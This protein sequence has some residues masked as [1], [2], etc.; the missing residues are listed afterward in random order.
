[1]KTNL[2]KIGQ[3]VG[4]WLALT[5]FGL[6]AYGASAQVSNP[7]KDFYGPG[8]YPAWT[9]EINWANSVNMATF[10]TGANDFE[11]FEAAR[12]LLFSQ[13]GGV[14]YYPAGTYNF[15]DHPQGPTGRGL[16]LRKGVVIVGEPP[17]ADK[18]AIVD[19]ANPGLTQ[20]GTKFLFPYHTTPRVVNGSG[21]YPDAWNLIGLKAEAGGTLKDV[22]HVG[23]AWVN[24]DAAYVYMGP[25]MPWS[26]SPWAQA[27]A[28][29]SRF[30]KNTGENWASR[31]ADGTHPMDPFMGAAP[32]LPYFGGSKGRFVFGC[33][34]DNSNVPNYMCSEGIG[35]DYDPDYV[36][37]F[38]FAARIAVYGANVL[39]ANNAVPIAP[40]N[41]MMAQPIKA[42]N[43]PVSTQNIYY[44][45][46]YQIGLDVNKQLVSQRDNRCNLDNG[47][48]YEKGVIIKDNWIFNHGNKG[49]EFCGKWVTIKNNVN[50]RYPINS[51]TARYGLPANWVL[52]R[53]GYNVSN[54]IDDNMA[55]AMDFGGWN[56]WM[57]HNWYTGTG[58]DPG[59]D[60]EGM[61]IQRHGGVEV[62]SF[63]WTYNRQGPTGEQ[64]Y[65]APYDV[66]CIGLFHGWNKQRGAVGV[67][68]TRSNRMEDISVVENIDLQGNPVNASGTNASNAGDFL[69][70]CPASVPGAPSN[71]TVVP[72]TVYKALVVS[73][74]DTSINEVAFK[75]ERRI[76]PT[77]PWKVIAYRPRNA[78]GGFYTY[79]GN[80][81]GSIPTG[82]AG[83][84]ARDFNEQ[85]W[86]DF[87]APANVLPEYRVTSV[88]C[89]NTDAGASDPVSPT[90]PITSLANADKAVFG[91]TAYPN[92][93]SS[94]VNFRF[95]ATKAGQASVQLT[96]HVGR[97]VM[98]KAL[99][100][101][102]G[103]NTGTVELSG[104]AKGLY[105]LSINSGNGRTVSKVV[106]Q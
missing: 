75:V 58:S 104:L 101:S 1:M 96:D 26:T 50:Y 105:N 77:D 74:T 76:L 2:T 21:E 60:G 83:Q 78:T 35:A 28:W 90:T 103:N 22:D 51:G 63:A 24:L 53:D 42:R 36:S 93:A 39:V 82:C 79:D 106:V 99:D 38:R 49:Y 31:I 16:M 94:K 85:V 37:S 27:G 15:A 44:D 84:A 45:Y 54:Q 56:L 65:I 11:K 4:Q 95:V 97:V 10:S 30:A 68:A 62:F 18:N 92:P 66:H 87:E 3:K 33:R 88:D 70:N 23:I 12:D 46:G 81:N 5:L 52:T 100:L 41:F 72:D 34:L 55:R 17:V 48:Y 64:G 71:I 59:N 6:F 47:P 7:M 73:W 8:N 13:G 32:N 57:D 19:T 86:F 80:D 89:A 69:F 61:L 102:M 25:D 29:R 20:L 9:D 40:K 98:T 43:T 91:L 14:L 67:V